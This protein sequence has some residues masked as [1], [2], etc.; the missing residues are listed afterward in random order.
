MCDNVENRANQ[1]RSGGKRSERSAVRE[2]NRHPFF[3][4]PLRDCHSVEPLTIMAL[5]R[6]RGTEVERVRKKKGRKR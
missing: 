4:P 5:I 6:V 3:S 1:N 2:E